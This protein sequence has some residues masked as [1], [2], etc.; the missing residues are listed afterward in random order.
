[1]LK[2]EARK[3]QQFTYKY[4]QPDDYH[5]CLDS[6]ILAEFVAEQITDCSQDL[7]VLDLCAGCG[8]VGLEL[9]YHQPQIQKIDFVEIQNEFRKHF[10]ANVRLANRTLDDFRFNNRDFRSHEGEYD[11]IVCNPPYFDA[12]KGK[13]GKSQLKNRCHFYL[14]GS[15]QELLKNCERLMSGNKSKAFILVKSEQLD[16]M[17]FNSIFSKRLHCETTADIRGTKVLALIKD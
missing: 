16:E 7:R 14:D 8:V 3:T 6:I 5:F 15:L 12:S 10:E 17:N 1:M 4:S 11:L 2:L 13:L 9:A